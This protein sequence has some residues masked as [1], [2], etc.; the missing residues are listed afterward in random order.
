MAR[1]RIKMISWL[2]LLTILIEKAI[3]IKRRDEYEKKQERLHQARTDPA[4]YLKRFGRVQ[5]VE[6]DE[7]T[8]TVH[9]SGASA[10]KHDG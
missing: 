6:S 7:S 10:N 1:L 3:Q 5:R 4:T 8:D 9:S 2:K